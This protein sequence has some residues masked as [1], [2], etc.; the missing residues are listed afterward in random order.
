M[1]DPQPSAQQLLDLVYLA[2]DDFNASVPP[3]RHLPKAPD[4]ALFD[5]GGALDSLGLVH[6]IVAL[7]QHTYDRTGLSLALADERAF[8]RSRSPFRSVSSLVEHLRERVGE[9]A[10]GR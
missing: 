6:L 4:A 3:E 10:L 9:Q 7:E 1:S 8:S 2:I 5:G